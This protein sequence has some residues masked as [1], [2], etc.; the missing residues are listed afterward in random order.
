MEQSCSLN[1]AA[2]S[3]LM[4]LAFSLAAQAQSSNSV[5]IALQSEVAVDDVILSIDQIAKVTG[6]S[7]ALRKRIGKL[8]VTEFKLGASSHAVLS[9]HVRFRLL[10]AGIDATEFQVI[11]AKR[12]LI[13]ESD[14][15]VTLRKILASA[16]NAVRAQYP[17][18]AAQASIFANR[19]IVV[20][21]LNVSSRADVR[22]VATVK[23]QVPL[24][25]PA[26]VDVGIS[27]N[28]SVR[29]VVA[30]Y[31]DISEPETA[32]KP[33]DPLVRPAGNWAPA[34]EAQSILVKARDTVKLVVPIGSIRVTAGGEALQD[35]KMGQLIRVRNISSNETVTGRVEASGVVI[36]DR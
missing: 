33:V 19:G 15:P 32:K 7:P 1:K 14:E 24:I 11:G 6:G 8:D 31:L 20:P 12:T 18:D 22:L 34:L 2:V 13:V 3:V 17:G 35:G 9:D 36:V 4:L 30:V 26:R 29:E 16:E 27:V 23:G 21:V 10:L 25:G 5:N 28:G